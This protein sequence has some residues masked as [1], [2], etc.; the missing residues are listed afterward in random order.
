MS[1]P[2]RVLDLF[3]GIGGFSLG[4]ER[5]GCQTAAFCEIDEFPRSI[6]TKRWPEVPCHDDVRTLSA[7]ELVPHGGADIGL[8]CGG[9]PCQDISNAGRRAGLD[10]AKSGLWSEMRRLIE[11]CAPEHVIIENSSH[12]RRHWLPAVISDLGALGFEAIAMEISAH[13]LGFPHERRRTWVLAD[14]CGGRL[15]ASHEAICARRASS[16]FRPRWPSQPGVSGVAD[17]LPRGV[18]RPRRRALGNAV[19]PLIP[20]VIGE[21]IQQARAAA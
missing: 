15:R 5:A 21:A 18:D 1:A 6:L 10:G 13:D 20:Q 7:N 8:V 4:L 19:V 9:F 12:G 16:E 2:L 17:G 11:E 3:S 14:T